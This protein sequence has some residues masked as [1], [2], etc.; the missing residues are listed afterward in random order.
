MFH[1]YL[2]EDGPLEELSLLIERLL[3]LMAS[4]LSSVQNAAAAL[5]HLV[6]RNGYETSQA[7]LAG[8][9][10]AQSV[11]SSKSLSMNKAYVERL[12]RPGCQTSVAL[13][14]LLGKSEEMRQPRQLVSA[15]AYQR[16]ITANSLV[17]VLRIV[18]L[19]PPPPPFLQ[20]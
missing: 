16:Q 7:Y 19:L 3:V 20:L 11:S 9:A 18:F 5:L 2:F 1:S 17:S 15:F 13:A 12:G 4:R 6:L 14:R 8:Q 10:M